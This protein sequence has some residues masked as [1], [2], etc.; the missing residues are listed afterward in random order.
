MLNSTLSGHLG[1]S[2]TEVEQLLDLTSD[3][4]Q[5]NSVYQS[6]L[7]QLDADAIIDSL[8]EARHVLDLKVPPLVDAMKAKHH[9]SHF[10]LTAFMLTNWVAGYLTFPDQLWTLPETHHN[11]PKHIVREVVPEVLPMFSDLGAAA[12]SWQRAFATLVLPLLS[13]Q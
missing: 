1:I 2:P 11:V 13:D 5:A 8:P 9:V 4:F 3:Q 7:A 12:P 6:L 10:P